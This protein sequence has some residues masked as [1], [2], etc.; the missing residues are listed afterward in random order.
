[1]STKLHHGY[2]IDAAEAGVAGDGLARLPRRLTAVFTPVYEAEYLRCVVAMA[3]AMW[4]AGVAS[5]YDSTLAAADM[6]LLEAQ[7]DIARTGVRNPRLDFQ[8][9][10]SV[11]C[12][13]DDDEH[14]YAL[15]FTERDAYRQA[16]LSIPGVDPWPYW[17]N[18]DR[19]DELTEAEWDTR[20]ST[21]DRV[22]PANSAPAKVGWS[23]S[24][25]PSGH[26]MFASR[27]DDD[28]LARYLPSDQQRARALAYGHSQVTSLFECARMP[29]RSQVEA[30]VA[31][32]TRSILAEGL[33]PV[34]VSDLRGSRKKTRP[35]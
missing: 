25:L 3:A 1:M 17:N 23:W 5:R 34:S 7:A 27:Q 20:R 30:A 19:P 11:L 33:S 15:L 32:V 28:R 21:W 6:A 35:F 4:D 10:V 2:R 8:C 29:E 31:E 9:E 13:P 18:T 24:L 22:L 14:L 16:W 26:T 12:D